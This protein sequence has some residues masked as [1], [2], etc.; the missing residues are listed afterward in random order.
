MGEGYSR[1]LSLSSVGGGA[2]SSDGRGFDFRIVRGSLDIT[3]P[4]PWGEGYAFEL[5][6]SSAGGGLGFWTALRLDYFQA[7]G[8]K[9]RIFR[10]AKRCA[11][12]YN[13][14]VQPMEGIGGRVARAGGKI[15]AGLWRTALLMAAASIAGALFAAGPTTTECGDIQSAVLGRSAGFCIDLPADYAASAPKRYPTLYFLHGLFENDQRWIDRGGKEILDGMLAEGKIGPFIVVLPDADNTFYVNSYDGKVRYEDF[16]VTELIPYIDAHYR[17]IAT[18]AERAVSGVSMGGYGSLHLAM[19]H[20]DLFVAASA[21]SAALLPEF[22]HP[23]PTEGR[24]GFYARVLGEAFGRPLS[25]AWWDKNNPL[26]LAEHPENFD[27]L[28]LYFDVGNHDRYGFEEGNELLDKILTEKHY[29]HEFYLREG[30]H[31][32]AYLHNYMQY[33]LAFHWKWFEK[34]LKSKEGAASGR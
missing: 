17:T 3:S 24:W 21:H 15:A 30:D 29:P 7:M 6:S 5:R 12:G 8:Q 28:K 31:G 33:S 34:G 9:A 26:K 10:G 1:E 16:F 25:E 22:P 13:D 11:S 20:P 4:L 27:G 23:I 14:H 18:R 2:H 32:W 19:Q